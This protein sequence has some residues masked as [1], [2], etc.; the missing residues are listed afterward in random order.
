MDVALAAHGGGVAETLRDPLNRTGDVALRFGLRLERP[1]RPQCFSGQQ[2]AGP[3]PKIFRREFIVGDVLEIV[4]DVG[5][6]DDLPFTG[7]V[8]V[9]K[10]LVARQI[11]AR[12]D[13]L[14][15]TAVLE[16]DGVTDAALA[17]ELEAY[18]R[19]VDLR[20]LVAHG[21]QTEGMIV[22]GVLLVADADQRLLQQLHDGREDFLAWQPR[23]L[24][25]GAG[26]AADAR[27]LSRERNEVIVFGFVALFSPTRMVAVLFASA[28]VASRRL[29]VAVGVGTDPHVRPRR[30]DHDRSDSLELGAIGNRA[31]VGSDVA[32]SVPPPDP[33]DAGRAV[34]VDVAKVDLQRR[35]TLQAFPRARQFRHPSVPQLR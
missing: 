1:E 30:R 35:F 8:D 17:A 16:I 13:D 12:L 33:A 2:R 5:R 9:L 22:A 34:V 19:A 32:K 10:Q 24:Q 11:A 23:F 29:N 20:V 14:R 26:A 7:F 25:I 31:A 27:K 3:R 4:V 21:R 18:V 28:R 6:V 15:E